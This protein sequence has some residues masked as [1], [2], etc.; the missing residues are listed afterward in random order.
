MRWKKDDGWEFGSTKTK[1][2]KKMLA[3]DSDTIQILTEWKQ[4]QEKH[5]KI[6]FLLSYNGSPSHKSTIN[7]IV[8]RHGKLA[9]VT[10][11]SA[12]GLRHSHASLLI[13]EQNVNPLIIKDR[14]GHED[15]KTT[16][17]TYGHLYDNTNFEVAHKLSG[18]V[19]VKTATTKQ[20]QFHGNQSFKYKEK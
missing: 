1:A 17:G 13:N 12:K 3:L 15:I 5:G 8:K 14:L 19:N 4:A 2:G 11:I 6:D 7:R 9:N 18:I 10:T 16:L 20:T